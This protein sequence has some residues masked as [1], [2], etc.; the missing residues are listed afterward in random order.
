MRRQE[1]TPE[2]SLRGSSSQPI[3]LRSEVPGDAETA[4]EAARGA[5]PG[6]WHEDRTAGVAEVVDGAEEAR[7]LLLVHL[8][9]HQLEVEVQVGD[10]VPAEVDA[11]QPGRRGLRQRAL[12]GLADAAAEAE[13][14]AAAAHVAPLEAA[15]R[16][17]EVDVELR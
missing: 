3:G 1:K 9:I 2:L 6:A 11:A 15:D 13:D 5:F 7:R 17:F 14:V 4:G 10:R 16:P 12:D 8:L